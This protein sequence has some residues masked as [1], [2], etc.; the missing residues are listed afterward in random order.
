MNLFAVAKVLVPVFTK[1]LLIDVSLTGGRG[2]AKQALEIA[3][4]LRNKK[5]P[6]V[7][8]TD[9]LFAP[10]LKDIGLS[11]DIVVNTQLSDSPYKIRR[12][13]ED[14]LSNIGYSCLVKIGA[15]SVGPYV[16]DSQNI[17][18]I[19]VDG[20]LPD[21][22]T[23]NNPLY[24]YR[25][26]KNAKKIL[27]TTQFDWKIPQKYPN[28]IFE[29]CYYPVSKDTEALL[30]CKNN[31]KSEITELNVELRGDTP[32]WK[33]D[34]VIDLV[35]TG[36]FLINP[37]DRIT[38][39]GW[40]KP[41]EYDQCIGFINRLIQDLAILSK[42]KIYIFLDLE[43]YNLISYQRKK[44]K[45]ELGFF[46][47]KSGWDYK[48]ELLLKKYSKFTLSRATN[49]QP[50]IA[51]IAKG[52]NITTPVP[53][54]GYMDE[55]TAADQYSREGLT[56]FIKYDDVFYVKK[57][58]DFMSSSKEQKIISRNLVRNRDFYQDRSLLYFI[59]LFYYES[60]KQNK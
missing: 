58:L 2:P 21:T 13:F 39:G 36:D 44:Y 31:N 15:R 41:R 33:R 3:I 1:P 29:T 38:Y 5:I 53:A 19:I 50:Y 26:Y 16:A 23:K 20:G 30:L 59:E 43:I 47:F 45:E 35:F 24:S 12:S 48:T 9:N 55:D 17:P 6:F 28:L 60:I 27:I 32:N 8:L 42:E 34:T 46:T 4:S 7:I 40:L 25:V 49:Y 52:G 10:K 57:L 11:P 18:Y 56:K 14:C 37:Y 22:L 54:D 51:L